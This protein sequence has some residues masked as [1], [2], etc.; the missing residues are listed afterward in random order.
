MTVRKREM[1]QSAVGPL[2]FL[3]AVLASDVWVA[4]DATR[5]RASGNDVVATVGP[6]S[7]SRPEHWILAC[8]LLWIVTFPLYLVARRAS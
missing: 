6:V 7:L 2:L 3:A 1:P 8:L 4:W 5:C